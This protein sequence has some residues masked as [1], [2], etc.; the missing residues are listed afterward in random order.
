MPTKLAML[1]GRARVPTTRGFDGPYLPGAQRVKTCRLTSVSASQ[2]TNQGTE[3]M[4]L[5]ELITERTNI[6]AS[7]LR[8][9][10][11][12]VTL[13]CNACAGA[14]DSGAPPAVPT[15]SITLAP[16]ILKTP[17]EQSTPVPTSTPAVKPGSWHGS[18]PEPKR[19]WRGKHWNYE[20]NAAKKAQHPANPEPRRTEPTP[21]PSERPPYWPLEHLND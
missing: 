8:A 2:S 10:V 20:K 1:M 6:Y 5:D 12:L 4:H 17:G 16:F 18:G 13:L 21:T 14:P 19:H 15:P 7:R 11:L 9:P 3:Q